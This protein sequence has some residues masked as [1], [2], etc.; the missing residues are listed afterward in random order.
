ME[1][2]N[3]TAE[4]RREMKEYFVMDVGGTEL[5]YGLL[6]QSGRLVSQVRK[7]PSKSKESKAVIMDNFQ[8]VIAEMAKESHGKLE[9]FAFAF[10]GEFD[11]ENGIS[12][13]TGLDK[14]EEIYN[15]NLRTEFQKMICSEPIC[16]FC[17]DP[18][19]APVVFIND[20][21]AFARGV[22]E[23]GE[24]L[25]AL[26]IGTGAGSAFIE[27]NRAAEK[28][29]NGVPQNGMIYNQPF[30]GKQIDDWISKRGL[31]ELSRWRLGMELDGKELAE[32]LAKGNDL[33]KEVYWDFGEYVMEAVMP[34]L[35]EFQPDVLVLGG[36]IMKS[37]PL[38]GEE[39]K[40]QC[41]RF[42]IRLQV[43]TRTSELTFVGLYKTFFREN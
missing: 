32:L 42:R 24:K 26:V 17:R 39:I 3:W 43:E 38:F 25:M 1:D 2:K 20:V 10:P 6:N 5:K 36:Q 4:V 23:P 28:G 14:Y 15:L 34:Y 30:Y 19:A 16:G 40:R 9:G 21:E 31:M 35:L 27:D 33:A 37:F 29:K 13:I 7:R 8:S 41:K 11:Y 18:E 22:A 12:K